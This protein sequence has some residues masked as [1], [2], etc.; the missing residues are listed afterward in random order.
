MPNPFHQWFLTT[1][2]FSMSPSRIRYVHN[3]GPKHHRN[4]S[5]LTSTVKD[6][7]HMARVTQVKKLATRTGKTIFSGVTSR[8]IM[9]T[10]GINCVA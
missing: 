9:A 1:A 7:P 5:S 4:S 2:T 10:M 8:A 6:E 3:P